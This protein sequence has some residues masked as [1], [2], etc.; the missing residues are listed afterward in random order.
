MTQ[1]LE[2]SAIAKLTISLCRALQSY[3]HEDPRDVVQEYLLWMLERYNG[4]V[5]FPFRYHLICVKR[6]SWHNYKKKRREILIASNIDIEFLCN[7][8]F[9]NAKHGITNAKYDV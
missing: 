1:I 9:S 7:P 5:K 8:R 2:T 3:V 6:R 4:I